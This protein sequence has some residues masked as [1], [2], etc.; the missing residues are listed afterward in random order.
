MNLC[1]P[2]C[3]SPQQ[4]SQG[5]DVTAKSMIV[6]PQR[7]RAFYLFILV[8]SMASISSA[9]YSGRRSPLVVYNARRAEAMV[10]VNLEKDS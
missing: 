5:G 7:R 6:P 1:S 3:P 10:N 4:T 2:R 8:V 9:T